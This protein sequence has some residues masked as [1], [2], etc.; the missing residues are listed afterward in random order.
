MANRRRDNSQIW[1][2]E[3]IWIQTLTEICRTG[4]LTKMCMQRTRRLGISHRVIQIARC[5]KIRNCKIKNNSWRTSKNQSR[6]LSRVKQ[7][8]VTYATETLSKV[9]IESTTLW[10]QS[11]IHEQLKEDL[12]LNS[13]R[14]R[15]LPCLTLTCLPMNIPALTTEGSSSTPPLR[16]LQVNTC[17]LRTSLSSIKPRYKIWTL[18]SLSMPKV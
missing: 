6:S 18:T 13:R 11:Q 14:S 17:L 10:E 9:T 4:R 16:P 12:S 2:N 1:R 5:W 15:N 8:T 7:E 3:S